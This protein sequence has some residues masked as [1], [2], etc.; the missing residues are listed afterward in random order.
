MMLA[1]ERTSVKTNANIRLLFPTVTGTL[2]ANDGCSFSRVCAYCMASRRSRSAAIASRSRH[3]PE[4]RLRR[5]PR[6]SIVERNPT[7]RQQRILDVIRTF[8]AERGYPPSVRE[9]GE[10]VGLSSSSTVQSH[11]KTLE[12]RGLIKRDPTKPR[13]LVRSNGPHTQHQPSDEE[14]SVRSRRASRSRRRRISR[15][16]SCCPSRSFA[17][18]TRS[19]C[20]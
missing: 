3:R 12:R 4:L 14:S 16:L 17:K 11:L 10:L 2:C 8:S 18:R 7:E 20:A 9:I 13:A 6:R 15:R 19:C 1:G 5:S